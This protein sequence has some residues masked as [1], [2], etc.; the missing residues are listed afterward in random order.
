[1]KISISFL[2]NLNRRWFNIAMEWTKDGYLVTDD[3]HHF[4]V[5]SIHNFLTNSYWAKGRSK[6]AVI[7]TIQNSFSIGLFYNGEQIGF[8]RVITDYI[9]FA[10]LCDVYVLEGHRKKGIGHFLM[11]CLLQHSKFS[12]VKWLLK[13]TYA[14]SLYKDFGFKEFE[15]SFGWMTRTP[16]KGI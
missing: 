7:T 5:D 3:V 14:Q 13:T 8:A 10:Y 4:D 15:S 16:V 6:E 11:D 9:T 1:M 2:D 12:S